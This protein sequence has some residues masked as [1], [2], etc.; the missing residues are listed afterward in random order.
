MKLYRVLLYPATTVTRVLWSML[1]PFVHA[2]VQV[3]AGMKMPMPTA[4]EREREREPSQGPP[5]ACMSTRVFTKDHVFA[6]SL[7]HRLVLAS[8]PRDILSYIPKEQLLRDFGGEDDY[9][10]AEGL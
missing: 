3:R 5:T 9:D 6:H 7:Q 2:H 4:P 8:S 1:R 10:F